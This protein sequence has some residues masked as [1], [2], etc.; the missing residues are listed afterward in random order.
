MELKYKCLGRCRRHLS[1]R[2]LD[3]GQLVTLMPTANQGKED[4]NTCPIQSTSNLWAGIAST[5]L[6]HL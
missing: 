5:D 6:S 4:A 1:V 3:S 2:S